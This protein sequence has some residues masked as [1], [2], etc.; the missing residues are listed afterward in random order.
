MTIENLN[1][2]WSTFFRD[3]NIYNRLLQ[4]E[5][6]YGFS[7]L[8]QGII[9]LYGSYSPRWL[10][11]AKTK[12]KGGNSLFLKNGKEYQIRTTKWDKHRMLIQIPSAR[13]ESD[14]FS[15]PANEVRYFKYEKYK[16][17]LQ[18]K[19]RYIDYLVV[20]ILLVN[21]FKI[22]DK[23]ASDEYYINCMVCKSAEAT[24]QTEEA[25][26]IYVCSRECFKRRNV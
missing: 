7:S 12:F 13:D 26:P 6:P 3:Q 23:F 5:D 4:K 20:Y 17:I 2:V 24:L 18:A 14:D 10:Y 21:G 15:Q 11:I 16:K 9:R 19:N 25:T 8:T 22:K 1:P